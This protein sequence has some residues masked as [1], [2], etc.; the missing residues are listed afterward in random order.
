MANSMFTRSVT[1][2]AAAL[3]EVVQPAAGVESPGPLWILD[4]TLVAWVSPA[5]LQQ[6][7]GGVV[8]L[9]EDERFDA[10]VL[11]EKRQGVWM[12]GSD[13]FRR[14][15]A[16]QSAAAPETVQPGQQVQIAVVYCGK[17]ITLYRDGRRYADYDAGSQE[18]FAN[19]CDILIGARYRGSMGEIGFFAGEIDEVRLYR[20]PLDEATLRALKPGEVGQPEPWGMWTFD[21]A[22]VADRMG[23]FPKGRL[24]NGATVAG[25]KLRLGGRTQ[26]ALVSALPPSTRAVHAGFFTPLRRGQ[27][28]DTWMYFHDGRYYMY[29]LAGRGGHWDG[30]ELAVSDDGVHWKGHGVVVR[31]RVGVTWMGTGHI[32]E[33]PDFDRSHTWVM[34]Y[35]EWFGDKQDIMFVTST[36]LLHW[37]KVD[38]KHRFVQDARWYKPKGR[39]DCIDAIARPDSGLYGYFTADPAEGKVPYRPC[40]FGFAASKD[41]I[42]WTA[43]PPVEGDIAGE[44]GGIQKLGALRAD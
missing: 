15:Q 22:E 8:S 42:T 1:V 37:I 12:A 29:Y 40:G 16:D 7:G 35:S 4:K 6:R 18:S 9:M 44:L 10:I 24:M 19:T 2:L 39:W 34:N 32:W 27:M 30:H 43:L 13:F 41:G 36:D 33:S 25:G 38:E 3:M 20:E 31:P 17:R 11:G 14:T 26:Y 21:E 23:R 5:D 28:W